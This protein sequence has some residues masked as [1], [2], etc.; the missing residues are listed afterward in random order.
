MELSFFRRRNRD[1]RTAPH[2][3]PARVGVNVMATERDG[4]NDGLDW[5]PDK[6][7]A[8]RIRADLPNAAPISTNLRAARAA[9]VLQ[10]EAAFLADTSGNVAPPERE[11]LID[12]LQ[13]AANYIFDRI[14]IA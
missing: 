11:A 4:G 9:K 12:A 2:A 10:Q 8:E 7:L 3:E 14:V 6:D 1:A 5:N 13:F